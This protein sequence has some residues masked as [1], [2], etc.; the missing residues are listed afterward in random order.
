MCR[1]H[2]GNGRT[3]DKLQKQ[4]THPLRASVEMLQATVVLY[5]PSLILEASTTDQNLSTSPRLPNFRRLSEGPG[6]IVWG[7]THTPEQL[8]QM[9]WAR[10]S[11]V[12]RN[13]R[14]PAPC[15]WEE[16]VSFSSSSLQ[17][18]DTPSSPGLSV[19]N[20]GSR[21]NTGL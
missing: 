1:G 21:I 17:S 4:I 12:M 20:P 11:L 8:F 5:T 19:L 15:G 2:H 3:V 14:P 13:A 6:E 10:R 16:T 7:V 18:E 9:C